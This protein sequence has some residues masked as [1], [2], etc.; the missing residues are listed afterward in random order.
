[1][2]SPLPLTIDELLTTTRTV[3]KRLDLARPVEREVILDCLAIAQQAP[4]GSN[5]QHWHFVVVTDPEQRA[6]L[7]KI[8]RKGYEI[9]LTL[10]NAVTN[11]VF[12]NR[13]HQAAQ[14]RVADSIEYLVDHLHEVPVFVIPCLVGR[15]EGR[16]FVAQSAMWG[17][18]APAA[19]SFMLA[20]RSRGLG[21]AWTSFHL[22][23]EEEAAQILKIP[24][25][26]VMQACLI[27]VA[28]TK[29]TDF[30]PGWRQSL[31]EIVSW[32]EWDKDSTPQP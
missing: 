22:F 29:G 14:T 21:T 27:P 25:D 9:Y 31:E 24:Y 3:R 2:T 17:S 20:A 7:A 19:W 30:K 1:M 10:P 28:Y 16:S 26:E 13:D 18:I 12:P 8:Y 4:T 32:N 6:A 23:F 15:P 5:R 11:N